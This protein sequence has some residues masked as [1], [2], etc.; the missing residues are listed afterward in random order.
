MV[1]RQKYPHP[2]DPVVKAREILQN[3]MR[4]KVRLHQLER[5]VVGLDRENQRLVTFVEDKHKANKHEK[6]GHIEEIR[7]LERALGN[8][9]N[10]GPPL[11]YKIDA[12]SEYRREAFAAKR[13]FQRSKNTND[14]LRRE[15]DLLRKK[16]SGYHEAVRER[17]DADEQMQRAVAERDQA[18]MDLR[19]A[20][21]QME[22]L[23]HD[24]VASRT[25]VEALQGEINF[26]KGAVHDATHMN[27]KNV[28]HYEHLLSIAR[29]EAQ[30]MSES[31]G[32]NLDRAVDHILRVSSPPRSPMYTPAL[33]PEESPGVVHHSPPPDF[34]EK[35]LKMNSDLQEA[36]AEAAYLRKLHT[37]TAPDA[38]FFFFKQTQPTP[39]PPQQ[40]QPVGVFYSNNTPVHSLPPPPA[41]SAIKRT[42]L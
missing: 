32:K 28:A 34:D 25:L 35:M 15:N 22:A 37:P 33:V 10:Q 23:R 6:D 19:T 42:Y 2:S 13:D 38:P 9:Q 21:R 31:L 16:N 30:N 41:R 11:V 29:A 36:Q 40:Q 26:L 12:G 4:Q 8:S 5:D 1:T 24:T 17:K 18:E 3:Y 27:S 7:R 14:G 39:K 20:L